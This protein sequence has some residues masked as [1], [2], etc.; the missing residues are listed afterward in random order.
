[1]IVYH[2]TSLINAHM[3]IESGYFKIGSWFAFEQTE[4]RRYGRV[5]L[6]AEID[7]ALLSADVDW[8]FHT[9]VPIPVVGRAFLND[10]G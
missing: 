8:Q 10:V 3:I 6:T 4:A 1:M 9:L 2:G 7:P 5:V